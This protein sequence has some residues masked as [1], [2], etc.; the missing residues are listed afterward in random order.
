MPF[1]SIKSAQGSEQG[2]RYPFQKHSLA[3]PR[4]AERGVDAGR[5]SLLAALGLSMAVAHRKIH[6]SI[7][8]T[9]RL[10]LL[11]LLAFVAFNPVLSPQYL[12]W[13]LPFAA[14]GAVENGRRPM[15][16]IAVAASLTPAF[17]PTDDYECLLFSVHVVRSVLTV[18]LPSVG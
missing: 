12:I 14:W 16:L 6:P 5:S 18:C 4:R 15:I 7:G 9:A 2:A 3:F 10:A 13:L 8:D 11:P 1:P 17:F